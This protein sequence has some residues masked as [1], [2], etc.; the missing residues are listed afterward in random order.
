MVPYGG[1][2]RKSIA[3]TL[4]TLKM[5]FDTRESQAQ[6]CAKAPVMAG[7]IGP[8][9]EIPNEAAPICAVC[10]LSRRRVRFGSRFATHILSPRQM[11]CKRLHVL[12]HVQ[13][14]RL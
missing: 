6:R 2:L 8:W 11:F 12:D 9:D 5:W 14:I 10:G 4:Y 13:C 7:S 1:L 3:R